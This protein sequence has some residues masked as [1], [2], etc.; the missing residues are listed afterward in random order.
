MTTNRIVATAFALCIGAGAVAAN[1]SHEPTS[2]NGTEPVAPPGQSAPVVNHEAPAELQGDNVLTPA[3]AWRRALQLPASRQRQSALL[4]IAQRWAERD[5]ERAMLAAGELPPTAERRE[6]QYQLMASWAMADKDAARAWLQAQPSSGMTVGF[7]I[8]LAQNA[9]R[10]ALDFS[11]GL[12]GDDRMDAVRTALDMWAKQDPRAAAEALAGL[13]D[14]ALVEDASWSV[15][16]EWS[17]IDPYAALDWIKT[18]DADAQQRWQPDLLVAEAAELDPVRA[19]DLAMEL[20]EGQ[21]DAVDRVL[22]T[23]ASND[24][25][26]ASAWLR[27]SSHVVRGAAY[28]LLAHSYVELDLDE[29]LDWLQALPKER[30]QEAIAAFTFR[31]QSLDE[32]EQLMEHIDDPAVRTDAIA[33][34]TGQW[35]LRGATREAIRWLDRVAERE[36]LPSLYFDVF[37]A[38]PTADREEAAAYAR[39]LG[40]EAQR[41]AAYH[42]LA[43]ST[44]YDDVP[45]FAERMYGLVRGAEVKQGIAESFYW[46][47]FEDDPERAEPYREVADMAEDIVR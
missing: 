30:Q 15:M 37:H 10:E 35:A 2:V 3:D 17:R 22:E 43:L 4:R 31:K 13:G 39:R 41:D 42:A 8:G 29:A 23:W 33:Q 34:I 38:W 16:R 28:A 44:L 11:L 19:L 40:T 26:A 45:D 5:P 32:A 6:V 14:D 36:D 21:A 25:R 20:A 24:P 9:P 46:Q 12:A 47:W 7:V 27:T 1:R 18:R